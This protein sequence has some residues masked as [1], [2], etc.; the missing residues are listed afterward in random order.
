MTIKTFGLTHVAIHVI[1]PDRSFRFYEALLG[2][3]LLGACE[4]REGADLS[5]E[6]VIEWGTPGSHDVIVLLRSKDGE[7][8]NTGNLEHFGFRLVSREEP[9]DLSKRIADAG[10]T[11]LG[12]GRFKTGGEAYAFARDPDGY[13][14]E[15]WFEDDPAWRSS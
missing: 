6:D 2:A 14:I 5:G 4:G 15:L 7:T 10:G 11:V 3:K 13:E 12:V 9:E 1:D 8:G